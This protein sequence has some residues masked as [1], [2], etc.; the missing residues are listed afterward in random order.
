MSPKNNFF[1]LSL[2]N[3][4]FPVLHG[5][6][7]LAIF[8]VIQVHSMDLTGQR[9][10]GLGYGETI[11]TFLELTL[12]NAWFCMDLFFILSGFLIGQ[13]LIHS[14]NG[15]N[16]IGFKRFYIRRAFRTFPLYY[17][18][19][20]IYW[21]IARFN[22]QVLT[23]M[24]LQEVP[25]IGYQELFYLSNYPFDPVNYLV[26]WSWSLSVE[27]HFYLLSP[28]LVFGLYFLKSHH[29]RMIVLFGL[30]LLGP[31][32]RYK[33]Y[34][35]SFDTNEMYSFFK[36]YAPTH[37][38]FDI[39]IAGILLAYVYSYFKPQLRA[40]FKKK[41][42]Q[43]FSFMLPIAIFM[44]ILSP[45][46]NPNPL[47]IFKIDT[48]EGYRWAWKTGIFY[49]G[50]LTSVAYCSL[51]L[52]LLFTDN[53]LTRLMSSKLLLYVATLGYGVYLVHFPVAGL[54]AH[55]F[56]DL[57]VNPREIPEILWILNTVLTFVIS[58]VISY[59]LHLLIEK[60]FLILR[61]KLTN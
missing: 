3:N 15:S 34:L 2:L 54:L 6:R 30:W 57:F 44:I 55:L 43:I 25:K 9:T 53:G 48:T 23:P 19:L 39:L 1:N 46:I 14:M 47:G 27:E 51:I 45:Q 26:Y 40:L 22:P 36:I 13:I 50:T 21:F 58:L 52:F 41:W 61:D 42:V 37:A 20:F 10:L 16:S 11:N 8:G 4:Q 7:V 5:L 56:K 31:I 60:P 18:F 17:A 59:F 12:R 29:W 28:I 32:I 35:Q 38:R 49:F 24:A 33:I